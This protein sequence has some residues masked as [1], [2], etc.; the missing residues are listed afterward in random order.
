MLNDSEFNKT[1]DML[2]QS[3]IYKLSNTERRIF[4]LSFINKIQIDFQKDCDLSIDFRLT[5]FV[6]L[7]NFL[8]EK[9]N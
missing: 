1:L 3:H 7:E 8:V 2:L 5:P 9:P 6:A 4:S